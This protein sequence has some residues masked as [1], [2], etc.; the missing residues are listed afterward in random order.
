ME[1]QC[2]GELLISLFLNQLKQSF[3]LHGD[4]AREG[5]KTNGTPYTHAVF[6]APDLGKQFTAAIDNIGVLF[7]F[8]DTIDHSQD[9]DDALDLVKAAKMGFD[10]REHGQTNLSGSHL[11]FFNVNVPSDAADHQ[12]FIVLNRSVA[13]KIE[14]FPID[15]EGFIHAHRGRCG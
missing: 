9:F 5:A 12:F 14:V 7:E 2:W 10:R 11:A 15:K 1:Y 3:Y 8:R 4:I 13:R 6:L